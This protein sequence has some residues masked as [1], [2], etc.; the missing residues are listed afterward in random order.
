MFITFVLFLV[1]LAILVFV[2]ELGH[3]SVAKFF[4]I[5]VDEFGLGFPPKLFAKK[6]GETVYT[7]NAIPFGGFVKIFGENGDEEQETLL[8]EEDKKNNFAY[9]NRG[10]QALVLVAGVT[11]NILFGYLLISLG[12]MIGLPSPAGTSNFGDIKNPELVITS[13]LPNS[14]ASK[15]G[16]ISGDTIRSVRTLQKTLTD[17]SPQSVSMFIEQSKSPIELTYTRGKNDIR[18]VTI[19]PSRDLFADR[20]VIGITMETI[21]TLQLSPA[22]AFLQGAITTGYL[23]KEIIFGLIEFF[24]GVFTFTQDFSSVSGPIGIA[25]VVGEAREVGFVH[26]LSIVALISFNLAV[27]NLIPFPALDG[28]RLLFVGIE[29]IIRRKINATV[30]YWVNAIGFIFLIILMIVVS[31]HDIWN[32]L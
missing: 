24:K 25:K 18:T 3:F 21:G 23:L 16:L 2:H 32:I 31:T 14:P 9:K 10:I 30:T 22:K 6:Y 5:R 26:V 4:G 1:I 20:Q 13:I 28:G 7:L 15:A 29:A 17:V 8:S 12:F 19:E 11:M 27:I